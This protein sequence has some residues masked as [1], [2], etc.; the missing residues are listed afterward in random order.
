MK[1]LNNDQRLKLAHKTIREKGT[2]AST[3]LLIE[4][5]E[6]IHAR[7]AQLKPDNVEYQ[8]PFYSKATAIEV[9]TDYVEILQDRKVKE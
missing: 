3:F 4:L 1:N 9:L 8:N 5:S 7:I 2:M 6:A